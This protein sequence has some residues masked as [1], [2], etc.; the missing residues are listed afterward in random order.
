MEDKNE[1]QDFDLDDILNEFHETDPE[2][3]VEVE[4]D[5]ELEE[6]L[7][8]PRLTIT[9]VVVRTS[10]TVKELLEEAEPAVSREDTVVFQPLQMEKA[11]EGDT[12]VVPEAVT[13]DTIAVPLEEL[14]EDTTEVPEAETP[15]EPAVEPAFEVEPEFVPEP[16]L[17]Q[18][19]GAKLRELKKKLMD[20]RRSGSMS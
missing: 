12:G 1:V 4:A 18:P 9:P 10:D 15:Q 17:F 13:A 19:K 8:M 14:T 11:A 2:E 6:L 5:E 20:G 16:I 7:H 3:S